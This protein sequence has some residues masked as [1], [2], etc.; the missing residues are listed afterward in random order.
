MR[1]ILMLKER[2][3]KEILNKLSCKVKIIFVSSLINAVGI[4]TETFDE[5]SEIKK[6]DFVKSA[7][8]SEKADILLKDAINDIGALDMMRQNCQNNKKYCA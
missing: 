6:F 1:A 2:A 5:I 4:E 8:L 3:D 7:S